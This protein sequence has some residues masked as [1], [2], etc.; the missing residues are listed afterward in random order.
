MWLPYRPEYEDTGSILKSCRDGLAVIFGSSYDMSIFVLAVWVQRIFPS[1]F[2][3]NSYA[4]VE[5]LD[6]AVDHG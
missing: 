4:S 3:Q 5:E 2:V 6:F 1:S